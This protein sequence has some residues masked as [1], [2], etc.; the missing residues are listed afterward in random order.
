MR[1]SRSRLLAG[2]PRIAFWIHLE[3]CCRSY[4]TPA[5]NAWSLTELAWY[6]CFFPVLNLVSSKR[7]TSYIRPIAQRVAVVTNFVDSVGAEGL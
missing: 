5:R 6:V 4:R 2:L 7:G 1:R 3:A